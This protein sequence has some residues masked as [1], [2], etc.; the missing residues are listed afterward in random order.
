[1]DEMRKA[2]ETA[3]TDCLALKEGETFLSIGDEPSRE[4]GM[5][6]W[7]I[8]RE[9]RAESMY[10]EI[11]P[12]SS[13]A[14]EPP[15]PVA[16]MMAEVKVI[17][18]PTSKS[19]SHTRARKAACVAGARVA[20]LPGITKD[21]LIRGLS[22]DYQAIAERTKILA[23]LITSGRTAHI[24]SDT[25]T[26][27]TMSLEGMKGLPDTGL[28]HEPGDF[29]NLP[30]GEAFAAPV[31]GSAEGVLVVDGSMAGVGVV[32]EH[33]KI[34]IRGGEAVEIVG[35]DQLQQVMEK[36][37]RDARNVAELGVGTN[38]KVRLSGSVLEDEKVLGT[39]HVALGDN[40]TFGGNVSVP[41]HLD[42]IIRKP[43]LTIDDKVVVKDG[44]LHV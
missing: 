7:E 3:L 43:V 13:H 34:T 38:D 6:F 22:A 29:S 2:I 26:D 27:L 23:E 15:A 11:V 25:G 42:G 14:E 10:V 33:I 17:V 19:L 24:A 35:S 32:K 40:S 37:G 12:R 44:K 31:Q 28:V 36:Y 30:A 20:T 9:K 16:A 5:A 4:I 21:V 41:V 39:V 8:A 1:M 18:A